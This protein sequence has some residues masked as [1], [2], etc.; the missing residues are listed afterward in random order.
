MGGLLRGLLMK[1]VARFAAGPSFLAEAKRRF[2][3]YVED[4]QANASELPDEYRVPVFQTVLQRGGESEYSQLVATFAK[5][6]ANIDQKHVFLSA[7]YAGAHRL[8]EEVLRW[9][10][11]GEIK[12][13]DFFYLMGSVSQSS[14]AG[15][16]MTW[17]FMRK[18]FSNIHSMVK[19]ASPSIM[20]A[21]IQM[22][23]AGY[24][25][26]AKA[27]EIEK[28]FEEHP[29][30]LNKRKIAQLL[31]EIRANAAFLDRTLATDIVKPEFWNE[32][33]ASLGMMPASSL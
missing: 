4:P 31:E 24:C 17:D 21:V 32:V 18:E 13:Q 14:K 3:R 10:I 22:S 11:G 23:T 16:D 19:A 30:P 5:L 33:T 29:L 2:A 1:L 7:G 26:T 12:I 8:K 20:D 9:A 6:T 15:L 28:F 27:D 25:S